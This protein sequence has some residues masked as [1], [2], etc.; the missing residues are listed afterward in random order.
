LVWD[1]FTKQ[2]ILDK[3]WAPKPWLSKTKR[4]DFTV[5]GEDFMLWLALKVKDMEY[6]RLYIY[7]SHNKF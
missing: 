4:M 2:K 3:W 1:A 5:G 6:S 7:K